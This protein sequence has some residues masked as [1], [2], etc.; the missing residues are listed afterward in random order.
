MNSA[1]VNDSECA[2]A[3]KVRHFLYKT[4]SAGQYTESSS[5]IVHNEPMFSCILRL[6]HLLQTRIHCLKRPNKLL[7]FQGSDECAIAWVSKYSE[8]PKHQKHCMCVN[9][10]DNA[11][12][13]II[14][15]IVHYNDKGEGNRQS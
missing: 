1:Y 5:A 14:C 11:F 9:V 15:D 12:I 2:G 6:Y 3:T 10:S 8:M 4:I 7:F 13:R